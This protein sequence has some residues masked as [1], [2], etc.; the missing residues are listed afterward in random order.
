MRDRRKETKASPL[1]SEL[2]MAHFALSDIGAKKFLFRERINRGYDNKAGAATDRYLVWNE[3]WKVA[4]DK[5]KHAIQ[6]NN[7]GTQVRLQLTSLKTLV[8]HGQNGLSQKGEGE[9]LASD[10]YSLTRMQT[11]A[12]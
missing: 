8:P 11:Q 1:F 4:G 5:K 12:E 9:W 6:V 3:D 7:R 2:Y 10:Y